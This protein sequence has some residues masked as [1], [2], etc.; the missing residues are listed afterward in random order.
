[1]TATTAAATALLAYLIGLILAFG[2]RTLTQYRATG[3]TGY[4][5]Y[6]GRP[7]SLPWWGRVLFVG[8]LILA[9]AAPILALTGTTRALLFH[10]AAALVGLTISVAGI[11]ITV[12]AQ[13]DMGTSW[14]IGVDPAE[15]TALVTNGLFARIRNPI[16]TGMLAVTAGL[17]AMVPTAVSLLALACLT[18]AVQIQVRAVEEPYL[19]T[20]H[21]PAY[22]TY[23]AGTG[24]F[25]PGL[26][27]HS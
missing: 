13:R 10:P 7:G 9:P 22:R 21:G 23:A 25:L 12:V 19:L 6:S 14:R 11:A 1:V 18:A 4:R 8:A 26:G 17:T 15:H 2:W 20:T 3:S 5:G 24:R 16:F 27:R